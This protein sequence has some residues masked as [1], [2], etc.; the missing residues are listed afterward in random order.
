VLV[1]LLYCP[2]VDIADVKSA[3][4]TENNFNESGAN[5]S[6]KKNKT[7][8]CKSVLCSTF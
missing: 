2:A 6:T 8:S 5:I 4:E 7:L 3:E 1:G